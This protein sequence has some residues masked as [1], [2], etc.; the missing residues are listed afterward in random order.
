M[1]K[2]RYI[3]IALT[4]IAVSAEAGIKIHVDNHQDNVDT[5]IESIREYDNRRK[6]NSHF[7]SYVKGIVIQKSEISIDV[8]IAAVGQ[9][10]QTSITEVGGCY[11]NCYHNCHGSRSWR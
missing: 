3:A 7:D 8:L 1:R 6:L 4:A 11:L 9:G 5:Y 2:S 10:D